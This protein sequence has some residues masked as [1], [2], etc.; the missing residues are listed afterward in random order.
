MNSLP[1]PSSPRL[2]TLCLALIL[3]FSSPAHGQ[4]PDKPA[5]ALAP[6][7]GEL[8]AAAQV[9]KKTGKLRDAL[10]TALAAVQ[11]D[12]RRFEA[13][14]LCGLIA[15]ELGNRAD[16]L[17]FLAKAVAL[18]PED[19]KV[20]LLDM[21]K[22]LA[23]P[24]APAAVVAP[25][26]A[27]TPDAETRRQL[28]VLALIAE[29]ADRASRL[30]DRQ[31]A[32]REYLAK[33]ADFLKSHP[34]QANVWT[35]R[36]AV[37]MELNATREAWAAGRKLMALGAQADVDAKQEKVLAMLER[38]GLLVN[39]EPASS[40]KSG[41]RYENSLGM[42]FV[43]VPG[44]D[45]LFCVWITRVQ[46]Y[47]TFTRATTRAW[48]KPGFTQGQE[49][50]A[51]NV[52]WQ[53][54]KAFC[55]WLTH[56]ERAEGRLTTEQSYRLPLDWEWS[57]AVGLKEIRTGTPAEKDGG[58]KDVYPWGAQWPPPRG[59]GNYDQSLSVEDFPNTSPAGS[60]APN[61]FG[62]YDMGGN[63]WQWCE[64]SIDGKSENRTLRGASW[65]LDA[66][67]LLQSSKRYNY[68]PGVATDTSGFRLVLESGTQPSTTQTPTR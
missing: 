18:A 54:A 60:F 52:S 24:S 5:P 21:A 63:V 51:V 67:E 30:E 47:E 64:D 27:P 25:T 20:R 34:E 61:T 33:S 19:R 13:Y 48:E 26:P 59:A 43:P 56:K 35:V 40:P 38:K 29:D 1:L 46:D 9:A 44:T 8:V 31:K 4:A 55:A 15:H 32:L 53:D 66:R 3:S 50:P 2:W 65:F 57:V 37:A 62:L 68:A 42:K 11:L 10:A 36:A 16:A 23:T 6:S 41:K 28:A 17:D 12:G 58:I 22:A 45:V 14:A 49:H 39:E 7:Y